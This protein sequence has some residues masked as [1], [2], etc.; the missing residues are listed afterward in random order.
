MCL[1]FLFPQSLCWVYLGADVSSGFDMKVQENLEAFTTIDWTVLPHLFMP[2]QYKSTL[3]TC[4]CLWFPCSS[5]QNLTPTSKGLQC[6]PSKQDWIWICKWSPNVVSF[7]LQSGAIWTPCWDPQTVR[8]VIGLMFLCSVCAS[9]VQRWIHRGTTTVRRGAQPSGRRRSRPATTLWCYW[10]S[11]ACSP[12]TC[13]LTPSASCWGLNRL[14]S[15]YFSCKSFLAVSAAKH[16]LWLR[17]K[18]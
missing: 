2:E 13:L 4:W 8:T 9:A 1:S 3:L 16:Y 18:S 11:S 7:T 14:S 15:W 6:F 17:G 10:F 5:F 12:S